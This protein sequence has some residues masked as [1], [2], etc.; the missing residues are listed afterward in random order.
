MTSPKIS[1]LQARREEIVKTLAEID[2]QI[3][4]AQ[5]SE[6][7]AERKKARAKAEADRKKAAADAMRL[8]EQSGLLA[9]PA[10]LVELIEKAGE[11]A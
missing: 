11:H 2:T 4:A 3:K 7:A 9:D 10:R 1:R 5:K 8:L 6:A